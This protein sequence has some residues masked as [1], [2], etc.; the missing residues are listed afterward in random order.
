MRVRWNAR[1]A[2]VGTYVLLVAGAGV[3]AMALV[4][5]SDRPVEAAVPPP[6]EQ[7]G[8][9]E[10]QLDQS[11]TSVGYD[12][13]AGTQALSV[14]GGCS[15]ASSG[16]SF[17][18]FSSNTNKG[19]GLVGGS[20]GVKSKGNGENCAQVE[21]NE[22]LTVALGA[23]ISSAQAA[24]SAELDIEVQ[25]DAVVELTATYLGEPAGVFT[26]TSGSSATAGS[27]QL[28]TSTSA[29]P[30]A[31]CNPQSSS[32]PNSADSDNCRWVIESSDLFDAFELEVTTGKASL[33][34]GGDGTPP[35][36]SG[37]TG[38]VIYLTTVFEGIL[39][40][41]DSTET[42]AGAGFVGIITRI[43]DA[44]SGG[45][46]VPKPYNFQIDQDRIEF[47]PS[48]SDGVYSGRIEKMVS[49][50]QPID[51]SDWIRYDRDGDGPDEFVPMQWCID[52]VTASS[53]P[54]G[55]VSRLTTSATLPGQDSDGA[56]ATWCVAAVDIGEPTS[57]GM[58]TA[59][60][61]VYGE[62]DPHWL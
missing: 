31:S 17:L 38:S 2:L 20:I 28:A 54:G 56:D 24:Y 35:A 26:L 19:V 21:P 40:C 57:S 62:D 7:A 22:R 23:D 36:T 55:I 6:F 33:Q 5:S 37:T 47:E 60:F 52:P 29:D 51:S 1:W 46:C 16:P 9:I 34:G 44:T 18:E 59:V 45:D 61:W 3:V 14:N 48:G 30:A 4:G 49:A 42:E 8:L 32:G 10:L 13:I 50:D 11:T 41:G 39:E 15:L 53:A 27:T 58:V 43:D 12:G 25:Q